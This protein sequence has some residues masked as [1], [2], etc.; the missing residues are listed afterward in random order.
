MARLKLATPIAGLRGK[1]GGWVFSANGSGVYCKQWQPPTHSSSPAQAAHRANLAAVRHNW[2]TLNSTQIG[3]WD[4]LAASPPEIDYD[5]FG[6]AF[7]L[8]GSAWHTRINLRLLQVG[9]DIDPDAPTSTP[10]DA[11]DSF[12]LEIYETAYSLREDMFSYTEDDF[13]DHF[14][15]LHIATTLSHVKQTYSRSHA[16]IFSDAI[17]E[18]TE[19]D[20]TSPLELAFGT[21]SE[22][23]KFFGR[24]FKQS[25]TGIRSLPLTTTT[26]A[27]PTP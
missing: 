16:S 12:G 24:L 25:A 8:S 22:N 14:A 17:V 1:V 7:L 9:E 2:S 5:P 19:T 15:I 3:L 27:L 4:A 13:V 26:L 6:D 10:V 21:V 11:P 20:I 18:A 23:Q